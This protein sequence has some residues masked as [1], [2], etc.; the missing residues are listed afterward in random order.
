MNLV[1]VLALYVR[2]RAQ[3][4]QL[5]R[6]AVPS[7]DQCHLRRPIA[8]AFPLHGSRY[9]RRRSRPVKTAIRRLLNAY[10]PALPPAPPVVRKPAP[11]PSVEKPPCR[12]CAATGVRHAVRPHH[13]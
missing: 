8:V 2:T 13:P 1:A 11:A 3:L 5:T 9:P 10:L 6:S 7:T 4:H 12:L